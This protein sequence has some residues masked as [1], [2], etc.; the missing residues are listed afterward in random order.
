M[1]IC[2][3]SEYG[4]GWIAP[5]PAWMGR[6]GHALAVEGGVWLIDPI[7]V[8][9]LDARVALLGEPRGV[10]QLLTRHR[11]DCA[12]LAER[13]G[14]RLECVPTDLPGTPFEVIAL[15]SGRTLGERALWWPQTRTL[16]VADAVGTVRYFCAP[17]R[18]L[19]VNPLWRL[20]TPPRALLRVEPEHILCGHGRGIHQEAT[21]ALQDA[22]RN[23]RRELPRVLPRVFSARRHAAV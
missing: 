23:A 3:E 19:G 4:F 21:R 16:V 8:D 10:I 11:R 13:F 18:Q 6:T 22:V 1:V 7:D 9:G 12:V 14:V 5:E 2:D 20:V 17:G 15:R